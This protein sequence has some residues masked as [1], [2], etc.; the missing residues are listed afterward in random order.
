MHVYMK[1][2]IPAREYLAKLLL[3][4]VAASRGHD[5]LLGALPKISRGFPPGIYHTNDLGVRKA[6]QLSKIAGAGFIITAQDEEHGLTEE[7]LDFTIA[8][9]FHESTLEHVSTSFSWGPWD[10]A[11][12][13]ARF[14]TSASKFHLTGSPRVDLWRRD[15]A[16]SA[17]MDRRAERLREADTPA[18]LIV[19]NFGPQP[20]PWWIA[21]GHTRGSELGMS[22]A[23]RIGH[24]ELLAGY[25]RTAIVFVEAI[26]ALSEAFP[27]T[28]IVVRPHPTET[29]GALAELIGPRDNILVTRQGTT[30]DWLRATDLMIHSGSTTAF[31][32]VIGG[33]TAI[34]YTPDGLNTE[35]VT[36]HISKRAESINDL[37]EATGSVLAERARESR[38]AKVREASLP[39]VITDRI[40][41]PDRAMSASRIVDHWEQLAA[42]HGLQASGL[43]R[44]NHKSRFKARAAGRSRRTVKSRSIHARH[45]AD[46]KHGEIANIQRDE[47]VRF[48]TFCASGVIADAAAMSDALGVE[49]VRCRLLSDRLIRISP[50][51]SRRSSAGT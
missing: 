30:T 21:A 14:P 47:S 8:T 22:T 11:A 20:T 32:A 16:I 39:D 7:S 18:V 49:P 48:P 37:V 28:E 26:H 43:G 44:R 46:P 12:L 34:S 33:S 10:Y 40:H 38:T 23:E 17:F 50:P 36:N 51:V 29:W 27:D 19:S 25:Q 3:G 42:E 2:V 9:R 24:M 1:M 13:Q 6:P 35:F 5:V 31:E 15:V 41:M 45:E 4:V